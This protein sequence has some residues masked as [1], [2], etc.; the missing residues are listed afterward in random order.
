M[1]N[2]ELPNGLKG[3]S[4]NLTLNIQHSTLKSLSPS[5]KTKVLPLQTENKDYRGYD[6]IGTIWA[7]KGA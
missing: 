3:A 4:I 6:R 1:L 5:I 2:V 7:H